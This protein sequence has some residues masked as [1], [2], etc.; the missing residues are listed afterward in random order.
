MANNPYFRGPVNDLVAVELEDPPEGPLDLPEPGDQAEEGDVEGP[1]DPGEEERGISIPRGSEDEPQSG[2]GVA[3][4]PEGGGQQ[5]RQGSEQAAREEE[6]EKNA[7]GN[8]EEHEDDPNQVLRD[9]SDF[10]QNVSQFFNQEALSDVILTVGE[11][12]FYGHKFVLAKSSE[13]FKCMLYEKQWLSGTRDSE[14]VLNE[15]VECEEA[16]ERFLQYLYTA[17]VSINPES[18]VGILCLADKYGVGSLKELVT[19]YMVHHSRSPKVTNA[20]NWYSWAKALNLTDLVQQCHETI[21]WNIADIIQSPDWLI[22]DLE[23]VCDILQSHEL[24]IKNELMMYHAAERWLLSESNIANISDNAQQMLPLVRFPQMMVRDLFEVETSA[25][26]SHEECK[27]LLKDLLGRAYRFRSLCPSQSTLG[28]SF[29]DIFYMPRDYIDL[30]VD[31]VS[32]QNTLRF[33]IQVDVRTYVGPVPNEQK[34]GEWKITYRKNNDTWSLQLYCHDSAMV[35]GE[36]KVQATILIHNEQEKPLQ[37]QRTGT[38][39]CSRG[40]SLNIQV[41]LQDIEP[42]KS[43][44]ILIKPIAD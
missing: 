3:R 37:V 9:E 1:G 14:V 35:N 20:L 25:L 2:E 12:R 10:I 39:A 40:N 5:S 36:A 8:M 18:A 43:M 19:K 33:G 4:E 22:M 44:V 24:I 17:S 26:A 15:S 16:F 27:D 6:E 29:A 42:S 30:Q 7:E 32:I 11:Q 21:T 38:F 28:V 13:V 41:T 31:K 34:E 23:F